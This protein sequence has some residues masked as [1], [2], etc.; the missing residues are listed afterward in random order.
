MSCNHPMRAFWTGNY[1]DKGK[2]EYIIIQRPDIEEIPSWYLAKR[3][4]TPNWL[5]APHSVH[6]GDKFL[7][8]FVTIPCGKCIACKMAKS[9]EWTTR[10]CIESNYYKHLLFLTLTYDDYHLPPNN[11][12]SKSDLRNFI[13]RLRNS[14]SF[15]YFACGEY[16]T[17]D[18]STKRPHYHMI[19]LT[20]DDLGMKPE[21]RPN[22][23]KS[24]II[25]RC[26]P[27]GL[28]ELNL[29]DE[30]T[31]AY[32]AGY[33]Y[34]KQLAVEKDN[35]KIKPF[36]SAS[37]K[38]GFGLRYFQ[39]HIDSILATKKVYFKGKTKSAFRYIWK[40]LSE[41]MDIQAIKDDL[42][43]Q[44]G[45]NTDKLKAYFKAK[46][47]EEIGEAL[48]QIYFDYLEDKRKEKI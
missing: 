26:W 2:K 28:Y 11:E 34:K 25:S 48:D 33:V 38:P 16:G 44:A 9:K 13:K 36:I 37:D 43:V 12:L 47:F 20:D 7:T 4:F 46:Y 39:E 35:H 32:T 1:T 30:N 42:M 5:V 31:I 23:F 40:K 6:N 22:A 3:G 18:R 29:G 19:I 17:T 41:K 45:Y 15:R 21:P 10:I 27:F 24:D 8:E 14:I